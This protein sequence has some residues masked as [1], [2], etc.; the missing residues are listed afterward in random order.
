MRQLLITT[1]LLVSLPGGAVKLSAQ[2]NEFLKFTERFVHESLALSPAGSTGAGYHRHTDAR[3]GREI[4]LDE[5]LDDYSA[6][7][8][9]HQREV[10]R[11]LRREMG[12]FVP[13]RLGAAERIDLAI[14]RNALDDADFELNRVQAH[15]HNPTL[16]SNSLGYAIFQPMVQDYAPLDA[17]LK[18]IF[19]RLEEIPAFLSAARANLADTDAVFTQA[20][21]DG[22]EG[23]I[24]LLENQL[25]QLVA[26]TGSAELSAR[27]ASIAPKAVAELR[28]F[29]QFLKDDL[30][31]RSTGSWRLGAALYP[32]KLRYALGTDLTPEDVLARAEGAMAELRAEMMRLAEPLHKEYFAAH[33]A[34]A[35]LP[36]HERENRVIREVLDKIAEEHPDRNALLDEARQNLDELRRFLKEK[37][38]LTMPARDNLTVIETP[39]FIRSA[40]PLGGFAPAPALEPGLGAYYWVTPIPADWPAERAESKLRENN[41]YTFRI[42]S[43]HEALP[44]HYVQFEHAHDLQP[45]A[46]R[47]LRAVFASGPY[48]EGWAVYIEHVTLAAGFLDNSPKLKLMQRK[49]TLRSVANAI[50]DVRMHTRNLSDQEALDLLMNDAFQERAEADAKLIR[51]KLAYTQLP[52]Y[53]VGLVEW[54]S[55]RQAVERAQGSKF[56]LKS[57][58]D[59][60]LGVG[61]IPLNELRKWMLPGTSSERGAGATQ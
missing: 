31:T 24:Y 15:R 37:D 45:P 30:A 54:Q 16:Y 26:Q 57:F 53:F 27:Y 12:R 60:A 35:D 28:G 38:F 36:A 49:W 59:R 14:M 40:Y 2:N 61:P 50:L 21:A 43:I 44:G 25:K 55:I 33:G 22:T 52:T 11:Q 56:N 3:T 34:H 47:A 29:L 13:A 42:F 48:V 20:A 51:A 32:T 19:A 8:L 4:V 5:H 41:R 10:T 58:H 7:G 23:N 9:E 6:A 18:H 17:R 1:I 46:R 39:I